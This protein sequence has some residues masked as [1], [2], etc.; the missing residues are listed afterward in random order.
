MKKKK[1][2]IRVSKGL[3]F[4]QTGHQQHAAMQHIE[5]K[6]WQTENSK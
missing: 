3:P 6:S 5:K 4:K 1:G 2:L